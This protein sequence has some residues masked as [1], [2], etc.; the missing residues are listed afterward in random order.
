MSEDPHDGLGPE[1]AQ[2]LAFAD[3]AM[4][5]AVLFVRG[6]ADP[7]EALRLVGP[8]VILSHHGP[9]ALR[10]LGIGER[11]VQVLVERIKTLVGAAG[12]AAEALPAEDA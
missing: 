2:G 9:E 1:D 4:E 5:L 10:A 8:A 6:G 11:G 7:H 12:A 3:A